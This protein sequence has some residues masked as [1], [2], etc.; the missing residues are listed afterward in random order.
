M[1]TLLVIDREDAY[2]PKGWVS[3]IL[4]DFA[5][6]T[7]YEKSGRLWKPVTVPDSPELSKK[8]A[9]EPLALSASGLLYKEGSITGLSDPARIIKE[10][11]EIESSSL[12]KV[13]G[14]E[15]LDRSHSTV[16]DYGPGRTYSTPQAAFDAILSQEGSTPFSETHYVRGWSGTYGQGA[17]G[18]VLYVNTVA[19]ACGHPLVIDVESDE[20]VTLDDEGGD[21]CLVGSDVSRVRAE[22][23]RLVRGGAAI[24]PTDNAMVADWRVSR[25]V[26]DGSAGDMGIGVFTY[27]ADR[28]EVNNCRITGGSIEA[29]GTLGTYPSDYRNLVLVRG[30]LLEGHYQSIM[31]NSELTLVLVNNTMAAR[32]HGV[33][34]EGL[35]PFTLLMA[36]NIFVPADPEIECI[37]LADQ[38]PEGL[39]LLWSDFNCFYPDEGWTAHFNGEDKT[40]DQWR[41]LYGRDSNSIDCDP[42]LDGD[43]VP[44]KGSPCLGAGAALDSSGFSGKKRASSIDMGYE[45]VTEPLV[46]AVTARR[47]PEIVRRT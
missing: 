28:L 17:S 5:K 15:G 8:R 20:D 41:A 3:A 42:L 6:P 33:K 38:G 37:H 45:Q 16:W 40:L 32:R 2:L 27:L 1:P 25:C 31:S 34:H 4:P 35:K 9:S 19:P 22:G 26:M 47:M 43:Y 46:P 21:G 30:C 29:L 10:R 7:D 24:V 44:V 39:S 18:Y 12:K 36:N 23:L 14:P 13:P 11:L